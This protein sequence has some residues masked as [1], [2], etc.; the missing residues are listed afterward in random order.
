[1]RPRASHTTMA[2]V[3]CSRTALAKRAAAAS[4]SRRFC[5]ARSVT[6]TATA[7]TPWTGSSL[8]ER[9]AG[10]LA[11][12]PRTSANSPRQPSRA[13]GRE[14]SS[15]AC[16]VSTTKDRKSCPVIR[17]R[18][19]GQQL[20]DVP[21]GVDDDTV[22]RERERAVPHA[23]HQNAVR[24]LRPLEGVDLDTLLA[25]DDERVDLPATDG[26]EGLLRLGQ[27]R[28]E[29]LDRSRQGVV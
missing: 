21:V 3:A 17:S 22:G 16:C 8:K 7:D 15:A 24:L 20:G 27:P 9:S 1:M 28:A 14:I 10:T 25:V 13:A 2:S 26:A 6:I 23:L 12:S 29:I 18:G 4:S 5:S 11:P 19:E